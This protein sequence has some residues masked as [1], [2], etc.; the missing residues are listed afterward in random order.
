MPEDVTFFDSFRLVALWLS[1]IILVVSSLLLLL[2]TESYS[3][4]EEK[5]GRDIGGVRRKVVSKIETDINTF[6][7]FLLAN[8][9]LT[10]VVFITCF[11]IIFFFLSRQ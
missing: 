11:L 9:N 4:L 1:P 2:S 8:K 10:A 3:V 6:Q 5:L 7:K